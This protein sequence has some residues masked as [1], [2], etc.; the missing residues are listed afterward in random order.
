MK[1]LLHIIATPRGSESNTLSVSEVFLEEFKAIYPEWQID[2]LNLFEETLPPLT[3]QQVNGKYEL[4]SGKSLSEET[5]A[6]WDQILQHINRFITADLFLI[7]T[8]M[9]N[10][11]IPYKLKQYIDTIFQPR[12]LFRYT[13]KGVEGLVKNKKM[14]IVTSRGGDYREPPMKSFDL[15]EPY[16]RAAF[17]FVG[18][19]DIT[20]VN[21]QALHAGDPDVR[22]SFHEKAQEEAKE[23]ARSLNIPHAS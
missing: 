3:V 12:Y 23:A 11:S 19:T 5:Q 1:R 7:S 10:L 6:V 2:T 15:Q 20:F 21:A 9:W 18:I 13:S 16:L 14:V 4:L 17:G 22:K 8:P